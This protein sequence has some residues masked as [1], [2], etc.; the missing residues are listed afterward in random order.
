ME[1]V[2]GHFVQAR[3]TVLGI[4]SP[5]LAYPSPIEF[6]C[7]AGIFCPEGKSCSFQGGYYI[8]CK[9]GLVKDWVEAHP[10]VSFGVLVLALSGALYI[11][12]LVVGQVAAQFVHKDKVDKMS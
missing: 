9:H 11:G 6:D 8:H 12:G 4:V 10:N 5:Y 1:S 2:V 3:K 7:T